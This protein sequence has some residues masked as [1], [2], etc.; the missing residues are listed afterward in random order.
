MTNRIGEAKDGEIV[1]PDMGES[2]GNGDGI[3]SGGASRVVEGLGPG[4]RIHFRDEQICKQT[5]HTQ[6]PYVNTESL[7][8]V[9]NRTGI[10]IEGGDRD[11]EIEIDSNGVN[12]EL[13]VLKLTGRHHTVDGRATRELPTAKPIS[14]VTDTG[15]DRWVT[16]TIE[17]EVEASSE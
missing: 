16:V 13:E 14:Q 2:A 11:G 4:V 9:G 5:G 15:R 3:S 10:A 12:K 8:I 7:K 1:E 6:V 17:S